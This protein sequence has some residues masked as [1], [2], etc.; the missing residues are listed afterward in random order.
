MARILVVDDNESL[1]ELIQEVLQRQGFSIVQAE[2][3]AAAMEVL[4]YDPQFD[5][6]VTDISM[7]DLDGLRLTRLVRIQYPHIPVIIASAYYYQIKHARALGAAQHL[8]KP[9]SN[10]Q[11]VEVVQSVVQRPAAA[12]H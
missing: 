10:N 7:P 8:H 5:A 6:I 12:A 3:G 4:R 9:F 1:R 2:N 11:L